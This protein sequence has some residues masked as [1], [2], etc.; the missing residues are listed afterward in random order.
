MFFKNGCGHLLKMEWNAFV[1]LKALDLNWNNV[2]D[3][4]GWQGCV[5][6]A[7]IVHEILVQFYQFSNNKIPQ[8]NL[9]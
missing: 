5:Y 7:A 4:L 2:S 9:G 6:P 1:Q 8:S 3:P